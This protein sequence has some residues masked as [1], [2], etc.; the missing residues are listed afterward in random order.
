VEWSSDG[1]QLSYEEQTYYAW[2][3]A[4][5][6]PG[7]S[8]QDVI[9]QPSLAANVVKNL[10]QDFASGTAGTAGASSAA[11]GNRSKEDGN[12]R[13]TTAEEGT[14]GGSPAA[15]L[16]AGV[17]RAAAAVRAGKIPSDISSSAPF[18]SD[19][20]ANGED[21]EE[22]SRYGSSGRGNRGSSKK[23]DV[24]RQRAEDGARAIENLGAAV[25]AAFEASNGQIL[26]TS[27]SSNS[28]SSS[29]S[30]STGPSEG[31]ASSE[32]D[33]GSEDS[34]VFGGDGWRLLL[35]LLMC[36]APPA[37]D[38]PFH[39]RCVCAYLGCVHER[40]CPLS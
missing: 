18:R 11:A 13:T 7:L 21:E 5:A 8:P 19:S 22:V 10:L 27:D 4:R 2:D 35:K 36:A 14:E 29:S 38:S 16:R 40:E 31:S 26:A 3:Q 12:R 23:D 33:G 34:N 32:S 9:T 28:G 25:I 24:I 6:G 17:A 15:L 30:A 20:A 37:G 1:S 39:S